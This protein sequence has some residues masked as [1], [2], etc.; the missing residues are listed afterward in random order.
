MLG[1]LDAPR[2]WFYNSSSMV[3]YY[4]PNTSSTAQPP[5]GAEH[6][7]A[8]RTKVCENGLFG[9]RFILKL[10]ILPRQ[11]RVK[12]REDL[13]KGVAFSAGHGARR[14]AVGAISKVRKRSF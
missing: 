12:H 1:E 8:T 7:A 13:E 11:A 9:P 3:L 10:I 6:F 4:M 2:E 14:A 5:P